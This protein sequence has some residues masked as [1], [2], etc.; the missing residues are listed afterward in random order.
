MGARLMV[1]KR[2]ASDSCYYVSHQ[3]G[4]RVGLADPGVDNSGYL[5]PVLSGDL[6]APVSIDEITLTIVDT[7]DVGTATYYFQED[8]GT[9]QG[10]YELTDI[11]WNAADTTVYDNSTRGWGSSSHNPM[12]GMVEAPNGDLILACSYDTSDGD[13]YSSAAVI[14]SDDGG[15]TWGAPSVI[16]SGTTYDW[17]AGKPLVLKNGRILLPIISEDDDSVSMYASDDNGV[18]WVSHG[19]GSELTYLRC[20][21]E[22]PNGNIVGAYVDS[23]TTFYSAVSTD[24]GLTW[25][26]E[27]SIVAPS[28]MRY[29]FDL[30]CL[31]NSDVLFGYSDNDTYDPIKAYRSTDGGASWSAATN[32]ITPAYTDRSDPVFMSDIGGRIYCYSTSGS[33]TNDEVGYTYS[34]DNGATWSS[35]ESSYVYTSSGEDVNHPAA[36]LHH[37]HRAVV[38]WNETDS[39]DNLIRSSYVGDFLDYDDFDAEPIPCGIGLQKTILSNNIAV[40][41]YGGGGLTDDEWDIPVVYDYG[42]QNIVSHDSPS[43]PWRTADD[44]IVADCY[45][46]YNLTGIDR[47]ALNSVAFFN[48]NV[49]T[50]TFE[51]HTTDTWATPDIQETISF[52]IE[53]AT[54]T[55]SGT[56]EGN[57]IPCSAFLANHKDH[58]LAGLYFRATS[59][60]DDG[61][62]WTITDNVAGYIFLEITDYTNLASSDIFAVFSSSAVKFFTADIAALI[63]VVI[64]QQTTADG[65]YQ[66]GTMVPTGSSDLEY[67]WSVGYSR[68]TTVGVTLLET[69]R[70][71]LL[72]SVG[73]RSRMEWGLE[74]AAQELDGDVLLALRYATGYLLVLIPDND[75]TRPV[76]YPVYLSGDIGQAQQATNIYAVNINLIEQV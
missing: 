35:T 59:G 26:G 68:P 61:E 70:G 47:Q 41:W 50:L 36:C 23:S 34:D 65:Y 43:W 60:T 72:P 24:G 6:T 39:S 20:M 75:A 32:P 33:M 74:Y 46:K 40:Q 21:V 67:A 14:I 27:V 4:P 2:I 57:A 44:D 8:S 64:P 18:T 28:A 66:I 51:A 71:I 15:D 17:T 58:A 55:I 73:R 63:R 62:T 12:G 69:P 48:C 54:G 29:G 38:V 10:R 13:A 9:L 53:N 45:A 49:R 31:H 7:G 3:D 5:R 19:N 30:I 11:M 52:D 1:Q 56:V 25:G 37:G 42:A 76:P 22:L 16:A